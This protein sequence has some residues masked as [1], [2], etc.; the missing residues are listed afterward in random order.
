MDD[1][2]WKVLDSRYIVERPWLTARCDKVQLPN[3]QVNDEYYVLEYPDWVNVIA[4]DD[5]GQYVMVRQYRHG[6][7]LT[8][9]ELCAGV[10]E[11]GE[12][13]LC[14]AKREL[15]EE[16]GYTGGRWTKLMAITANASTHTNLT[17]CYLAEGVTLTTAQHLDRTEDVR[18]QLLT[19]QQLLQ[20][21]RNDE[22]K[23][24]LMAAPLWKYFAI[25]GKGTV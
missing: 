24:A 22:V 19:E 6:I 10:C 20:L 23:Q 25:R 18:V 8:L 14:A 3:G 1:M 4:I 17:H 16:T 21:M 9:T 2:K 5:H 11:P 13:P 7:G 12:D 15:A